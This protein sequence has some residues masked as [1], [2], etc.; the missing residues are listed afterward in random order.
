ML[1]DVLESSCLGQETFGQF[2]H[3]NYLPFV[4]DFDDMVRDLL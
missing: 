1:Q 3:H 2:L 4:G